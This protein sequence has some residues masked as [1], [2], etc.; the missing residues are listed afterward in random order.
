MAKQEV[1]NTFSKRSIQTV[2]KVLISL[3]VALFVALVFV[4]I[5]RTESVQVA[6]GEEIAMIKST[7]DKKLQAQYYR[8]LL[9]RVGPE[10]AQEQLYRSGLPFTG[11]THLINH[12]SGDFIFEK[13]G[14]E[15]I[16]K[17]RRYFLESCYHGLLLHVISGDSDNDF[18]DIK[19]AVD[20]CVKA[21]ASVVSQCAHGIGH[22]YVA[23]VGYANLDR[24][25]E[26][27]SKIAARL[28]S[29][30]LYNC[31]DGAFM[32]NIWAVHGGEP[33]PD[34]WV[35]GNDD[36]YPCN[37]SRL[38]PEYINP[39]WSN[40]PSLLYQR[41]EGNLTKVGQICETV[42]PDD[43]KTTCFNGLARQIHPLTNNQI[44]QVF[45]LCANM[46]QSWQVYCQLTIGNAAFSVGDR[47]LPFELCNRFTGKDK[48]QC[49]DD[50]IGAINSYASSREDK[51]SWCNL[52]K[53]EDVSKRNDCLARSTF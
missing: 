7:T 51:L 19:K 3:L 41:Y 39:C 38:K 44:D 15:G 45:S 10:E 29:F 46:Q 33:S 40:Q 52:I 17:C 2:L 18:T 25:L 32:E 36:F 34:R 53:N 9:E 28:S 31:H 14:V 42:T 50:L 47:S 5:R 16:T 8:A 6:P 26:E 37:D 35:K 13:Y 20:H 11:E 24:A 49:Y 22:G 23:A 4:Y 21:G 30:P 27:C 43:A 1:K 48:T 12:T